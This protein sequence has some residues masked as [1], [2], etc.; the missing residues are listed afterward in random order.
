MNTNDKTTKF[1]NIYIKKNVFKCIIIVQ[2][3]QK[4]NSKL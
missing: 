3:D 2:A 4:N 1:K